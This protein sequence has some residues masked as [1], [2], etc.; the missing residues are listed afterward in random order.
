MFCK[1]CEK[2]KIEIQNLGNEKKILLEK[3]KTDPLILENQK[4]RAKLLEM[5]KFADLS[6]PCPILNANLI[7][8]NKE[9]KEK[10]FFNGL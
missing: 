1:N 9:L 8:E 2:Y 7:K 5:F 6:E 10:L 4:L 3:T